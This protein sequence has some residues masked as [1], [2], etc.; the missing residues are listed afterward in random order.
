[1]NLTSLIIGMAIGAALGV[2]F[3]LLRARGRSASLEKELA[4]LQAEIQHEKQGAAERETHLKKSAE[5][6]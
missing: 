1:M 2:L 4:V 6:L 5:E 3:L